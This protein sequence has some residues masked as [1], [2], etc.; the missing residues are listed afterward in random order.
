MMIVIKYFFKY[1]FIIFH[2]LGTDCESPNYVY[3]PLPWIDSAQ[4][5]G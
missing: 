1:A 2:K 4:P 3:E 5:V